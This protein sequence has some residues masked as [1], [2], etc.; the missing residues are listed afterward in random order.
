MLEQVASG[1]AALV[2]GTHAVIEEQV[3]F[4]RLGLAIVDE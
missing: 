3:R 4:A 1:E 2:V